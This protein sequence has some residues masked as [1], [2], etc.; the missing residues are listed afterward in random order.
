MNTFDVARCRCPQCGCG[1]ASATAYHHDVSPKPG[2]LS[3][4]VEC[5]AFLV[6]DD[7]LAMQLL[8]REALNE[9]P[10]SVRGELQELR[11]RL[12]LAK[13]EAKKRLN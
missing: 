3:I 10:E 5:A 7:A 11:S 2:H 12:V 9:L 8:S 4:C 13:L 1:L 6:F